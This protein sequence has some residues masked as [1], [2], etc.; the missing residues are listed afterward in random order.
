MALR[1]RYLVTYDIRDKRRLRRIHGLVVDFG[2]ILQYSVYVCDL[3]KVEL[4]EL[5][6]KLRVEMDSTVDSISIFDLGPPQGQAATRVEHLG[7]EP[8]ISKD[9]VQVW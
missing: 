5:R 9:D 4:I 3:T 2:E 1:N 6:S 7:R 8:E